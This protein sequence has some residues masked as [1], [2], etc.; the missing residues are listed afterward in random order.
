[1]M[2]A[3]RSSAKLSRFCPDRLK[4][5][6]KVAPQ[7]GFEPATLRL[8][9]GNSDVC[10]ALP[11]FA[12]SCRTLRQR[13]KNL[14]VFRFRPMRGFAALCRPLLQSKGKKR[15][16]SLRQVIGRFES[17]AASSPAISS[18]IKRSQNSPDLFPA[19]PRPFE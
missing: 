11:P 3:S 6:E 16:T 8:T 13:P 14:A 10:R 4:K 19:K 7:A 15:A 5:I 9:G 18:G 2:P 17:S 12:G 1:L